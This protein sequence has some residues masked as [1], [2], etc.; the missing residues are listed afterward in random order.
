MDSSGSRVASRIVSGSFDN[1]KTGYG[2]RETMF[3]G[4]QEEVRRGEANGHAEKRVDG[5]E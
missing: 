2:R 5:S 3:R 4:V 1:H